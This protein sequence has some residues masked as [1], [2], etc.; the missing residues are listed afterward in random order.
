[1]KE[2]ILTAALAA[3]MLTGLTACGTGTAAFSGLSSSQ[4]GSTGENTGAGDADSQAAADGQTDA[5]SQSSADS[6]A[7][8]DSQVD[9]DS[10]AG[11]DSSDYF[12]DRDLEQGYDDSEAVHIR[13]SDD[14]SSTDSESGISIDSNVITITEEGVYVFSGSL[15]GGQIRVEAGD[16]DKVEIV[17]DSV[18]ISSSSGS[19]IYA[20]NADK[21]F[22]TAASGSEN[23]LKTTGTFEAEGDVN[24]D[25]VIFS[26]DDLV[27]KGEGSLS[28]QS[29]DN[30][31]VSKDDLKITGGTVTIDADGKGLEANNS[32]RIAG[33]TITIDSEDDS[34]H[35]DSSDDEAGY[36]YQSGG[37]LVLTSGD[38]GIHADGETIIAGGAIDI[39][40]C[41]EGLE[42]ADVT[43]SG[44]TI[45]IVSDDDGI[46][47]AG[48]SDTDEKDSGQWGQDYFSSSGD[49]DLTISG[50]EITID[51]NGDGIDSNGDLTISGGTIYCSGQAAN[52]NGALDY[53]EGR[54]AVI[55]GG[56]LIATGYSGMAETF[57]DSSTQC[58]AI[59][60][61]SAA[62]SETLTVTNENGDILAQWQPPKDYNCVYVSAPDMKTGTSVTLSAG[63]ETETIS[64]DAV[65]TTSGVSGGFGG[66]GGGMN[67]GGFGGARG[68]MNRGDADSAGGG[69]NRGDADS[70]DSTT[71]Q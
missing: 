26:R 24:I 28:I 64:L 17:L 15:P 69:M 66:A 49:N 4:T 70:A 18:T 48:G 10:Q 68:G 14:G 62:T 60:G 39:T 55:T 56:T 54:E 25:G 42:G 53:G 46:N 6:Q 50:G 20:A 63:D 7:D 38:D 58:I 29:T 32:I 61:L 34:I 12:T 23:I 67:R 31:I 36:Y 27:I 30:G 37:M 45:S 40:Q 35:A 41:Y 11:T 21:V 1:M 19:C 13:L 9:A 2:K 65:V 16:D 52:G 43:I 3:C 8:A 22:V 5:D 51:A 33:G 44:G 57:S 47:A 71:D 59:I